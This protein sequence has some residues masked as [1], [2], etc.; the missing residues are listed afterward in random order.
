MNNLKYIK[1]LFGRQEKRAYDR[2]LGKIVMMIIRP[3]PWLLLK[4]NKT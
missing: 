1:S 3:E 4:E 2:I